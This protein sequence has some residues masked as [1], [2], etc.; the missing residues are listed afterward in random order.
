MKKKA[1]L[2]TSKGCPLC[3]EA[4]TILKRQDCKIH[5]E[6][7]SYDANIKERPCETIVPALPA[8]VGSSLPQL[9]VG[10]VCLE[11]LLEIQVADASGQ[12]QKLLQV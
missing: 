9:V 8:R 2:Y 10:N 1:I 7:V 5:F 4:R 3:N 11:G 12:L 6:E